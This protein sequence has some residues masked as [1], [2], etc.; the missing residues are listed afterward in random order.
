MAELNSGTVSDPELAAL[1]E[2]ERELRA[3]DP[4]I[5]YRRPLT[6]LVV[7][8]PLALLAETYR[9][10][11]GRE[12]QL[13]FDQQW[14]LIG[15]R[16]GITMPSLLPALILAVAC[17]GLQLFR[18][19]PGCGQAAAKSSECLAGVRYGPWC[20]TACTLLPGSSPIPFQLEPGQAQGTTISPTLGLPL[21]GPYKK[22]SS[23]AV[24]CLE[25][26]C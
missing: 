13:L 22:S 12:S 25:R 16:L 10:V 17:I 5:A 4:A 14:V 20:V 2:S 11:A 8:F 9:F 19:H 3:L 7:L 26:F 21:A 1:R 23:F 18:R 15:N 24:S 6:V